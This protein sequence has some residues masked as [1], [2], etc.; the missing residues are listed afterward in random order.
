LPH[1]AH[2]EAGTRR[3][4]GASVGGPEGAS[5]P[6]Y[7]FLF[8]DI[9]SSTGNWDRAPDL[10]DGALARHDHLLAEAVEAAGGGLVKHTGDGMLAVFDDPLAGVLAAVEA[11][12]ALRREPW[13][14]EAVI[15]ARMGLHLGPA[16]VRS[17]DFF[18]TSP[19]RCARIMGLASGGQVLVSRDVA[20][21][22][23]DE[24]DRHELSLRELGEHPL[25]GLSR[26]EH[27]FQVVAAGLVRDFPPPAS[28][29]HAATLPRPTVDLVGRGEDLRTVR[30]LLG[31]HRLVTLVGPGGVGKTSLALLVGTELRDEGVRSVLYVDLAPTSDELV[32]E[33][34]ARAVG[35]ERADAEP[36]IDAVV[37]A[38][39]D[40][41]SLL[42]LDN[43]E[44]VTAA[45][46]ELAEALRTRTTST[47]ILVTSQVPIEV[48]GECVVPLAPLSSEPGGTAVRLFGDRARSAD[49]AFDPA[50]HEADIRRLCAALDGLPL[51]I[52]LAASRV[53]SLEPRQILERLDHRLRFLRVPDGYAQARR[54][55]TL[56]ATIAFSYDLL[57][58]Q[59]QLVLARLGAFRGP[60]TLGSAE[61]TIGFDP[62]EPWEVA[63]HLD[64]LV[65]RS[66]ITVEGSKSL[67]RF[68]LLE[69]IAVF[70]GE[71]LSNQPD[72][73]EVRRRHADHYLGQLR[74]LDASRAEQVDALDL[75]SANVRAAVDWSA[76]RSPEETARLLLASYRV[77][78]KLG[79]NDDAH[80]W[81]SIVADQ[82]P[83]ANPGEQVDLLERVGQLSI[84]TGRDLGHGRRAFERALALAEAQGLH[85]RALRIR[86]R[87]ATALS[88]YPASLDTNA[89][90]A[91]LEAL[92]YVISGTE[93]PTLHARMHL[94]A[95]HMHLYRRESG[96]GLDRA[97]LAREFAQRIGAV[98]MAA[99]ALA[100][101]GAHAAHAGRIDEGFALMAAA[102]DEARRVGSDSTAATIAWRR[103][104]AALLLADPHEA[105]SWFDRGLAACR[106]DRDPVIRLSVRANAGI[107]LVLAGRLDEAEEIAGDRLPING[108]LL[109]PLVTYARSDIA[110]GARV[111]GELLDHLW[112]V[113]D[114]ADGTAVACWSARV[115]NLLG[116]PDRARTLLARALPVATRPPSCPYYEIPVRTEL[117]L[118]GDPSHLPRLRE[119]V[120]TTP[121]R[122][123]EVRIQL[124][125]AEH[126]DDDEAEACFQRSLQVAD[127]Y[128]LVL[129][130]IEAFARRAAH[131]ARR[132]DHAGEA[133]DVEHARDLVRRLRLADTWKLAVEPA[134]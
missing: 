33:D 4:A 55:D 86:L 49:P 114:F 99:D 39:S 121:V 36:A 113:G 100:F 82:Q 27:L 52:E 5:T 92:E 61:A 96:E 115:S 88:L 94:C 78:R 21:A 93:D 62:I 37:R 112:R 25:R 18:G 127:R 79:W 134:L 42:V 98:G 34:V 48:P 72:R 104:Y 8:T 85:D 53:R 68:R 9:V 12:R 14:P 22:I 128:H 19:I 81:F 84:A 31:E 51:A 10:M 65:R 107:A 28:A 57:A 80:V 122:G 1:A 47:S 20:T 44:H 91:H 133:E 2:P 74:R 130:T 77:V 35:A 11:Q 63:D 29:G 50:A 41:D 43:G 66:L 45:V 24:L 87:L 83:F 67:R 58:R 131:R 26:P 117:A 59:D 119:I 102:W 17:D 23:D 64:R 110:E 75:E 95:T 111:A 56:G 3:Q 116:A 118:A 13:D 54:G 101:E 6:A 108:T 89:A 103:G 16:I 109:M 38:L 70:A 7:T 73:D 90:S 106:N 120:A 71:Q 105:L 125:E 15:E 60:F 97:R 123:L 32:G 40:S 46:A 126:A 124:A 30:R 69:S 132:R 76:N 129:D